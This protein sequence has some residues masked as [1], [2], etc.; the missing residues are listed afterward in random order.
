LRDKWLILALLFS[1]RCLMG[2]QFESVGALGPLL[3][4]EGV[5]YGQM[6]SSSAPI[7]RQVSWSRFPA[8]WWCSDSEI[9]PPSFFA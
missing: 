2:L 5:D 6:A 8:A 1:G 4:A 9:E 3:K 7:W